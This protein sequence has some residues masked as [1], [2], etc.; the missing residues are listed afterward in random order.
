MDERFNV[1]AAMH[2][3]TPDV[4]LSSTHMDN[5]ATVLRLHE[6]DEFLYGRGTCDAKGIIAAQIAAAD[7]CA[8]RA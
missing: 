6:D 4:V 8:M 5:G 2:G 7:R 1:Y 3:I